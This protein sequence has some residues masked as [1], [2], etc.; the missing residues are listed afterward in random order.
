MKKQKKVQRVLVVKGIKGTESKTRHVKDGKI[1]SWDCPHGV[2]CGKC[3]VD[4][5]QSTPEVN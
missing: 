1:R 5:N 3:F 4:L 2:N